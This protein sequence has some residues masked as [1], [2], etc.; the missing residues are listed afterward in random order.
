VKLYQAIVIYDYYVV[1]ND[2]QEARETLMNFIREEHPQPSEQTAIEARDERN[3][4]QSW[5]DLK[6]LVGGNVSDDDF[7]KR[8]KGRTTIEIYKDIYTKQR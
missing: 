5:R 4:R 3:V 7:E 8:C 1:A 6:P 2:P